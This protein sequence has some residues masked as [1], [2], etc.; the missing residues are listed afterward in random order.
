M[1]P[2]SFQDSQMHIVCCSWL[3][4]AFSHDGHIPRSHDLS[5]DIPMASNQREKIFLGSLGLQDLFKVL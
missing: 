2:G 4:T 5:S 3:K 1:P